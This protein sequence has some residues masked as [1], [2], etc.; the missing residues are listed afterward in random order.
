MICSDPLE[1]WFEKCGLIQ[2]DWQ[3]SF[4][5]HLDQKTFDQNGGKCPLQAVYAGEVVL[6]WIIC[7]HPIV[8]E[9]PVDQMHSYTE[10]CHQAVDLLLR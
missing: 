9:S 2:G 4:N 7:I 5:M 10:C 3:F 6:E 8:S 1:A